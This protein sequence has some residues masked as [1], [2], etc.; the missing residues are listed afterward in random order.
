M[1]KWSLY[2]S[3]IAIIGFI[4]FQAGNK[5]IEANSEQDLKTMVSILNDE[6]ILVTDWSLYTRERMENV[7]MD[8]IVLDLKEKFP[9]WSWQVTEDGSATA[10]SVSNDYVEKIQITSADQLHTYVMYEVK[11]KS[12]NTESED[13]YEKDWQ[14]RLVD[15]FQGSATT[16]SCV[17]G[18]FSDKIDKSLPTFMN[19]LLKA[20]NAEKVEALEED[21]FLSTSAY[22][23][24]FSGL[25]SEDH[26]MNLQL[27][28][29]K[30][31]GLGGNTT[32]VVGT[33][34]ITIE[35]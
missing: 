20:F 15:I 17:K 16:F 30:P 34:I 5:T 13:F 22:S 32:L 18:E 31:N 24:K 14:N 35:Y 28:L 3:I 7:Q 12:W 25:L 4:V 9:D 29:R 23:P 6:H 2:L 33:P 26:E 19:G 27:G 1:N 8:K 21:H 10:T 11:G